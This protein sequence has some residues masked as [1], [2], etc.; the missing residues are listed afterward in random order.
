MSIALS[1][2]ANKG[3]ENAAWKE[4]EHTGGFPPGEWEKYVAARGRINRRFGR[5]MRLLKA[6]QKAAK[7]ARGKRRK[8]WDVR[9]DEQQLS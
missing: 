7:E 2:H 9:G 3:C 1:R 6:E 5:E 4:K 8:R